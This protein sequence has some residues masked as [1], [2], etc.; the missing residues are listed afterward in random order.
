M[1]PLI[2]N[3]LVLILLLILGCDT[4]ELRIS[5]PSAE[6][7]QRIKTIGDSLSQKLLFSLKSELS[8]AIQQKGVVNAIQVCN[9]KA[10]PIT[11]EIGKSSE[12]LVDIKRTTTKYRNPK[13]KPDEIEKLAL[14][15]F[16]NMHNN[17]EP[18]PDYY[19]QKVYE[20]NKQFFNYYKPLKTGSLCLLC[21][22]DLKTMDE[23][24]TNVLNRLY[25]NDLATGYKEGDF[26]ALLRIKVVDKE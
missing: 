13:N 20:N 23:S 15:Y 1:R 3:C 25:P 7:T 4:T 11:D 17:N 18:F 22:G 5:E 21:H 2:F 26:R 14:E 9:I 10:L 8:K 12:Y 6:E 19:I 24:L 16:K